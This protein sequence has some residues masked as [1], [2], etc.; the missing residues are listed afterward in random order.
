VSEKPDRCE[1]CGR[2]AELGEAFTLPAK[3][4]TLM[5]LLAQKTGDEWPGV[6]TCEE[7][8]PIAAAVFREL[9]AL[10]VDEIARLTNGI[11]A[12]AC[13]AVR[14]GPAVDVEIQRI[15]LGE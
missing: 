10:P 7:C 12:A 2:E 3:L 1:V 8:G 11:V 6:W 13:R 9:Y 5:P 14:S 15:D 4:G